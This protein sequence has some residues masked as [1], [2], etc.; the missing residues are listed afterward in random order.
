[1]ENVYTELKCNKRQ[2]EASVIKIRTKVPKK[3][4]KEV[5]SEKVK[6]HKSKPRNLNKIKCPE[7]IY[8]KW[9]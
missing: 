7:T 3:V 5:Q 6:Q 4:L 8:D 2:F 1:M 9:P